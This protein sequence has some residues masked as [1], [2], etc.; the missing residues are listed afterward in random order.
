MI[1]AKEELFGEINKKCVDFAGDLVVYYEL[2]VFG[3]GVPKIGGN[4]KGFSKGWKEDLP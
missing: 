2:A 4:P 1:S 3:I